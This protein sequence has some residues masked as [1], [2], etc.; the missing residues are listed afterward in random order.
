MS[1]RSRG[2]GGRQ[3]RVPHEAHN[4]LNEISGV[5]EVRTPWGRGNGQLGTVDGY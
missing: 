4:F 2:K 3:F 5:G 1:G